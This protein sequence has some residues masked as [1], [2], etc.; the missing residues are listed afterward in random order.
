M[1][2]DISNIWG[3]LSLPDL[4]GLER[5]VFNAHRSVAAGPEEFGLTGA[6]LER[7]FNLYSYENPVWLYT[8]ARVLLFRLGRTG[9]R[10]E[11]WGRAEEMASRC[12]LLPG[13]PAGEGFVTVLCAGIPEEELADRAEE[14]V[15]EDM[16]VITIDLGEPDAGAVEALR[17]FFRLSAALW[18]KLS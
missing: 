10:V 5:A 9:E 4:L 17:V 12:E 7:Y 1:V 15:G 8:A 13:D 11:Y 18:A 16:P 3:V 14:L 6:Q 2:V